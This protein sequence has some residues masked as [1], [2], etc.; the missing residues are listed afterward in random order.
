MRPTDL[1]DYDDSGELAPRPHALDK[2]VVPRALLAGKAVV[3]LRN[4]A[5]GNRFTDQLVLGKRP[6]APTYL[7]KVLTGTDNTRD[8]SMFG[9]I[10]SGAYAYWGRSEV[11]ETAPSVQSFAWL[12]RNQAQMARWPQ[13]ELWYEGFCLKCGKLLSVPESIAAEIGPECRK[14]MAAA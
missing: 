11:P 8:Y 5:T 1:A 10:R 3:T 13:V 7:V 9:L 2:D 12:W 14:K 6:G 4:T